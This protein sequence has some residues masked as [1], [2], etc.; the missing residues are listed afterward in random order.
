MNFEEWFKE[1]HL[2]DKHKEGARISWTA[3]SISYA[4]NTHKEHNR[5]L[6]IELKKN[7]KRLREEKQEI[8]I[9]MLKYN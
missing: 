6:C 5:K 4:M 3:G 7:T 9:E 8:K 1:M 2:A